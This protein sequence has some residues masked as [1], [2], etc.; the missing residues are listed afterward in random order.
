MIDEFITALTRHAPAGSRVMCAQ[1]RGDPNKDGRWAARPL[2]NTAQLDGGA[3]VYVTVSSMYPSE[4]GRYR[5]RKENFAAGLALMVDDVGGGLGAKV[6]PE[7]LADV[8]PTALIETSPDN[9]QAVYLFTQPITDRQYFAAL[10]AAFIRD[11]LTGED[12]GMAGVNRVFRPPFGV[13]GKAKYG[14]AWAVRCAQWNPGCRYDPEELVRAFGL[15][16]TPRGRKV[17]RGATR[18]KGDRIAHFVAVRET[19]RAS[20][21]LKDQEPDSEGWQRVHCPWVDEH[22]DHRDDGA[23]IREPAAENDWWGAFRCHHAGCAHRTWRELSAIVAEDHAQRLSNVNAR[24][25]HWTQYQELTLDD[26]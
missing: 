11:Q 16:L 25:G 23:A 26:G 18:A 8:P 12:T 9:Y 10:I 24:A 6:G 13:N 15:R 3:N 5:R 21:A 14:G 1:F 20:G 17:P 2:V 7:A 4:D 22:T 19:L